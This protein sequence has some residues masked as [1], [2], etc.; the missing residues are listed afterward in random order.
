MS[1]ESSLWEWMRDHDYG[2][3]DLQ[4]TRIENAAV[5]GVPDVEGFLFIRG[6]DLCEPVAEQ[7]WMEL[8]VET[9][10]AGKKLKIK[11]RKLRTKQVAWLHNRARIKGRAWIL[12]RLE[13]GGRPRSHYL[14]SGI[15]ARILLE[16][17]MTEDDM[18]K[19]SVCAPQASPAE[20]VKRAVISAARTQAHL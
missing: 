2:F 20:I 8:K 17:G 12:L 7:F 13:G 19:Y 5:S 11:V 1:L 10:P 3:Y 4:M 6:S 15:F 18:D 9:R 14:L 16:E